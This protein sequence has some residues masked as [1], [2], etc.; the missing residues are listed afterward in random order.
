MAKK[1]KQ[2]ML[3]ILSIFLSMGYASI[4]GDIQEYKDIIAGNQAYK[5]ENEDRKYWFN[6]SNQILKNIDNGL[7][8]LK[9][10]NKKKEDILNNILTKG[11]DG[12]IDEVFIDLISKQCDSA[13]GRG[14]WKNMED[15]GYIKFHTDRLHKFRGY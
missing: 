8:T 3:I 6:L 7:Q 13:Y 11:T 2:A 4:S 10:E 9:N 14:Q 15:C 1:L 5:E 12:Y